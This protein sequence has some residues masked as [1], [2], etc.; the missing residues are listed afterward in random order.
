MNWIRLAVAFA[1]ASVVSTVLITVSTIFLYEGRGFFFGNDVWSPSAW[2]YARLDTYLYG[3]V[4]NF[5][6][7]GFPVAL[8]TFWVATRLRDA[9][10]KVRIAAV[11]MPSLATLFLHHG[12]EPPLCVRPRTVMVLVKS[13]GTNEVAGQ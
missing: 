10:R 8:C 2:S 4:V 7:A 1:I 5:A 9:G 3:V 12:G 6:F 13:L 11:V